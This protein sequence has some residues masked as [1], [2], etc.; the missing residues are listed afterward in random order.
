[1]IATRGFLTAVECTKSVFG[2]GSAPDPAGG[3]HDASSD[4]LV[5]WGG[6][7]PLPIPHPL[8]AFGVSVSSPVATRPRR[9]DPKTPSEFFFWIRP[10]LYHGIQSVYV[11]LRVFRCFL[12]QSAGFTRHAQNQSV[13]RP[14][15]SSSSQ[16]CTDRTLATCS[17]NTRIPASVSSQNLT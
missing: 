17:V 14:Y 3:A 7:T 13:R 10:C 15:V 1:M 5:G 9:L 6:D 16:P 4:P 12:Y 2:R 8:D 11:L